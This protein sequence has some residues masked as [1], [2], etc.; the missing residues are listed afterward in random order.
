LVDR[1][2]AFGL[3]LI[4]G[5]GLVSSALAHQPLW[6]FTEVA[7][8]VGCG[9]IATAFAVLRRNGGEPLDRVLVG[10]VVVLC[11]IKSTQYLYAGALAF[12]SGE[13]MLDPDLLRP[14][15]P[16]SVS[17]ASSRHSPAAAGAFS[18]CCPMSPAPAG[19]VF[20][21]LCVWWLIAISGGTRYVAW[22][23][24]G[25]RRAGGTGAPG[26]TLA[27]MA[28][29]GGAGWLVAVLAG[30]YSLGGLPGDRGLQRC[31]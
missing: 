11:L 5:L 7:V 31:Q 10:V 8:F 29:G 4:I 6:A 3:A 20:A 24:R 1:P 14:V 13:R 27:R 15:F 30:V 12:A 2:T 26:A 21:L 9:A 25:R 28:T 22:H 18:Y 17:T 19:A 16:T 23:G